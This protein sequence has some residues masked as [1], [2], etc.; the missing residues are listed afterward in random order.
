MTLMIVFN[1][2]FL[3]RVFRFGSFSFLFGAGLYKIGFCH[4]AALGVFRE[5][6]F[7]FYRIP[8]S[9]SIFVMD[10]VRG[11]YEFHLSHK[12]SKM[13]EVQFFV[14]RV[15]KLETFALDPGGT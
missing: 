1:S 8:H 14:E 6:L 5:L 4:R 3:S 11:L 7:F 13:S 15:K 2:C 9:L 10:L 12:V